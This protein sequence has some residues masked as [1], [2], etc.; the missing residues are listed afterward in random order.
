[1]GKHVQGKD[2]NLEISWMKSGKPQR[3]PIRTDLDPV[4]I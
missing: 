3:T 4:K 1:M 2:I